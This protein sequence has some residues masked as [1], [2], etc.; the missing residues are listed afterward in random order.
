M[1][2]QFWFNRFVSEGRSHQFCSFF[3][4]LNPRQL[5]VILIFKKWKFPLRFDKSGKKSSDI[6]LLY[7]RTVQNIVDIPLHFNQPCN[8]YSFANG[9]VNVNSSHLIA[10]N[11]YLVDWESRR[12]LT[13]VWRADLESVHP[14]F[15]LPFQLRLFLLNF[16]FNQLKLQMF[17]ICNEPCN[18]PSKSRR[19]EIFGGGGADG[20]ELSSG[21]DSFM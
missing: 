2:S 16:L 5:L 6:L 3:S 12:L 7:V 1:H 14:P 11:C 19:L 13:S 18:L 15:Q 10:A 21:Y 8:T 4:I 17:S 20:I 9:V